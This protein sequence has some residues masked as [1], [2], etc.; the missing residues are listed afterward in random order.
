MEVGLLFVGHICT[1]LHLHLHLH[2]IFLPCCLQMSNTS[3]IDIEEVKK[4]LEARF[5]N[6]LSIPRTVG[7][8]YLD[9]SETSE[10]NATLK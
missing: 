6:A 3:N 8:G 2:S 7:N 4:S 1:Q 9:I 10:D 5:E